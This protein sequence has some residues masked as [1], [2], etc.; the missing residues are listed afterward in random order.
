MS[1]R[2]VLRAFSLCLLTLLAALPAAA[3]ITFSPDPVVLGVGETSGPITAQVVFEVLASAPPGGTQTLEFDDLIY[4]GLSTEPATVSYVTAPGQLS[5]TVTFRLVAQ[6]NAYPSFFEVPVTNSPTPA[7]TGYLNIEILPLSVAPKSVTVPA[8]STSETLTA[9][10]VFG[11]R[12]PGGQQEIVLSGLPAGASSV[13]SPIYYTLPPQQSGTQVPFQIAVGPAV[14][15]GTYEIVVTNSPVEVGATSFSLT[16]LDPGSLDATL[17]KTALDACIGGAAVSN[18]VTVTPMDGYVG[19]ATVTF[20]ALPA[21]LVVS[22]ASIPV[23][24]MPPARTVSFSVAA[25]ADAAAGPK[26]VNVLVSGDSG[27]SAQAS[28]TVN[29]LAG[30]FTPS[31]SPTAVTLNAGAPQGRS[32]RRS[33]PGDARRPAT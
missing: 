25:K 4:Y 2:A 32:R 13:P 7:G 29:V 23:P 8:G 18:S 27:V 21:D 33:A 30:D 12:F 3:T 20:P 14:P 19:T 24:A 28:F 5:A 26:T 22:P 9:T 11:E 15:P 1:Q 6:P 17:E 31:L 10:I 16:V